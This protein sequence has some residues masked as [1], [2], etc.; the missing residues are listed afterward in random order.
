MPMSTELAVSVEEYLDHLTVERN[1]AVNTLAAYRRDLL[2]YAG[3]LTAVGIRNPR[4]V[5]EAELLGYL[6]ALWARS[7]EAVRQG[8]SAAPAASAPGSP[9]APR[10]VARALAAV[11]GYHRHLARGSQVPVDPTAALSTP[12]VGVSLPK[13]LKVED[14][15][16]LLAAVAG[17]EPTV[18]RDRALLELLY[19]AGLRASEAVGLDIDELDVEERSV[20]VLGKGGRERLVPFGSAAS[21]AL[22]AWLARGRPSLAGGGSGPAVFVNARGTRLTRQGCWKI[23]ARTARRADVTGVSPHVLRHSF[24]THLLEGGADIRVVQEL[25]GHASLATTQVYTAVTPLRLREVYHLA[26]PR[27]QMTRSAPIALPRID[28]EAAR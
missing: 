26:H 6:G 14:V 28:Q 12:L 27:A 9:R 3:W 8:A 18:L 4:V 13:A 25:L 16:R 24:A 2:R 11:R 17:Q 7:P 19:G 5:G 10:S 22:A 21:N 15:E 20:R 1:L 23:L